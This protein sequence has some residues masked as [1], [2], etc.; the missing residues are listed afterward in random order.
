MRPI[1]HNNTSRGQVVLLNTILFLIV[2]L[3]LINGIAYPVISHYQA[4]TGLLSS[5]KAL[6][7]SQSGIDEALYRLKR[8]KQVWS[9]MTLSLA[10]TTAT[11]SVANGANSKVITASTTFAGYQR[12][13]KL[14]L[15]V[16]VGAAFRYGVQSGQGGFTLANTSS[17]TGNIFSAG[18]IVG[19][20]NY[21]YGDIISA[22]SSGLVSGI[23]AT[24]TVYSHTIQNSTINK[25]AH[26][27]SIDSYS[28]SHTSGLLYP[29]SADIATTSFPIS[30]S[31]IS[32]WETDATSTGFTA[33]C[34]KNGTFTI[35]SATTT[36]NMLVPCD[37]VIK[38]A[39]VT[40]GGPIWVQGNINFQ[41]GANISMSSS[42]GSQNVPII[43][44]NQ[45]NKSGS[46]EITISSGSSFAGSGSTG[47]FVFV[48]SMN[49]SAENSGANTAIA[50]NQS[51]NH[52]VGYAPHGL[53]TG[54]QS[55]NL[56]AA[57]AYKVSLTQSSTVTYDTALPNTLFQAGATGGYSLTE[58]D[59]I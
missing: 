42:L 58:W 59:E 19:G 5:K 51:S 55:A 10:S 43:A 24:G 6:M 3:L 47:S 21:I 37:L 25:D 46:S 14:N 49:N 33:T 17:V 20:G 56:N 2:S 35:S 15:A 54:S 13:T 48:I 4:A 12:A 50:I 7:V 38:S 11:I 27:T 28:T 41:V 57:T 31:Q 32:K 26:Y 29:G 34:D 36:G 16:G 22:G 45:S 9:T 39:N 18:S 53:I 40:I 52:L 1:K 30:D 8:S 23:I 44:D